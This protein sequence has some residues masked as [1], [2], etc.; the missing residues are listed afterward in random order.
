MRRYTEML[1]RELRLAGEEVTVIAPAPLLGRL[2]RGSRL[3]K[4]LGYIDKFVL[5]PRTIRRAAQRCDVVHICDHSNAMYVRVLGEKPHVVTCHDLLAVRSARG[6]FPQNPVS[7]T[8]RFLQRLIAEGLQRAACIVCVSAKTRDDLRAVLG[9]PDARL[10]V[11]PLPV[12]ASFVPA[13]EA[14]REPV[15]R[16]LGVPPGRPFFLHVG[17]NHWYKNRSAVLPL[18]RALRQHAPYREA[19]LVLAG[20]PWPPEFSAYLAQHGLER[21]AIAV[22]YPT[23]AQLRFLYS[24]ATAFLFPSHHEGFGWPILEAEA[25]GCPVAIADR[26]PMNQ[27]AGTAAILI[28][29]EDAEGAAARIVA[30]LNHREQLRQAGFRNLYRFEIGGVIEAYVATY[31]SVSGAG[32]FE[33]A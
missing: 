25:C 23:D 29:I 27:V 5:F 17:A 15:L 21:E 26:A 2:F 9:I 16:A 19:M 31:R 32:T 6:E 7:R 24:G 20:Q 4:W 18:F 13:T 33:Y 28:D 11:I 12:D 8:G 10:R 3:R 30:C 1:A 22:S 14:E